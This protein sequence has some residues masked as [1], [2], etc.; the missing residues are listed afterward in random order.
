MERDKPIYISLTGPNSHKVIIPAGVGSFSIGTKGISKG[1][2]DVFVEKDSSIDWNAFNQFYTPHG[3]LHTKEYPNGDWPRFFYYS[4]NDKGFVDWSINRHIE[5]FSWFPNQDNSIDLTKANIRNFNLYNETNKISIK[6]GNGI[7]NVSLGGDLEKI[8]INKCEGNP[9]LYFNP[10]C[11]KKGTS[12]YNLPEYILLKNTKGINITVEPIGQAFNCES[13]LQFPNL[14]NLN[15]SG[16][17]ANF[18]ALKELKELETIG[19]RFVPDLANFPNL[20]SW[21]NLKSFIG[22]N[23]EE[24]GGKQL[25][26]QLKALSKEKEIKNSSVSQLRKKIWFKNEY[27]LPFSSWENKNAKTAIKAYKEAL[28]E[29][30]KSKTKNEVRTAIVSFVQVIN[31]LPNIETSEREDAGIAVDYLIENSILDISKDTANKWFDEVRD[32]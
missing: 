4:G 7:L 31:K 21:K 20:N 2:W 14:K 15:L 22:W 16:N 25:K 9:Y 6:I 28:K 23:V 24:I 19:L 11:S 5:D 32:F 1:K 30:K 12:A 17:L 18:D 10:A 26:A 8:T 3:K 27:G 13:L 29:I